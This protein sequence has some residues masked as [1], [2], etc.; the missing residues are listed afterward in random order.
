[1]SMKETYVENL[2]KSNFK[3]TPQR[4]EVIN[5]LEK[6]NYNHFTAEDVYSS[7]KESEPTITL[8]TV[9]NILRAL[10][11]SGNINSFEVN[12]KTWFETNVQFHGNLVCDSCGKIIDEEVDPGRFADLSSE[13]SYK[14]TGANLVMRGL[15]PECNSA[16]QIENH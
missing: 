1:M 15:C 7:V 16:E 4:L 6:G 10:K 14:I 9:Y 3:I 8:A 11:E 2:R 12:G 5:F 13:A